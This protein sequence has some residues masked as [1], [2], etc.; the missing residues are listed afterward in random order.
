[1]FTSSQ[2]LFS[3]AVSVP[4]PGEGAWRVGE[5]ENYNQDFSFLVGTDGTDGRILDV[6]LGG[7]KGKPL[8]HGAIIVPR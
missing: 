1:M 6:V 7:R 3:R 4:R 5:G 8:R 2:R